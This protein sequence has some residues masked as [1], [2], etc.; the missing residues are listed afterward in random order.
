MSSNDNDE[1]T[2]KEKRREKC[3]HET[4]ERLEW[5]KN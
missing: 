3:I 5:N 4:R 1:D 2:K